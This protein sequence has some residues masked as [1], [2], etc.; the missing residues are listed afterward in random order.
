MDQDDRHDDQDGTFQEPDA[1]SI[2]W[3][4]RKVERDRALAERLLL[5]TGDFD[6]A[7]RRFERERE[8][9]LPE[10]LPTQDRRA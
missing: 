8:G 5:E 2:D 9:P 3:M 6:E 10:S 4:G 7:R 1:G